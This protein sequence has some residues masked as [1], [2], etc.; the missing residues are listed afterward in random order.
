MAKIASINLAALRNRQILKIQK[1]RDY[2]KVSRAHD[3][4]AGLDLYTTEA[5]MLSPGERHKAS[6][7]IAIELPPGTVG[8]IYPR[9]GKALNT[10]LTLINSV[11]VIDAGYRGELQAP[12]VNHSRTQVAYV[13]AGERIAQLVVQPVIIPT[14]EYVDD[15]SVTERGANGFGST[16]KA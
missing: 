12:L 1:L 6:L 2:A 11:G 9:S 4:D 14:I 15:L 5:I 13:P 16:G 8:L 7:G 3:D 10:G